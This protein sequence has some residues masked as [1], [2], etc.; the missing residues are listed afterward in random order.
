MELYQIRHFI[1]VA[2]AGGFTKGAQH[3]SVSQSAISASIAKIEAELGVKLLDRRLSPVGLTYAGERFFE[4]AKDIMRRYDA[5]TADLKSIARPKHLKIGV[6][7]S[8]LLFDGAI[9][10]LLSS[11]KRANPHL[12]T[13]VIDDECEHLTGLLAAHEIDTVLTMIRED[14]AEL[15]N[16]VLYKMPYSLAVREDHHF[17]NRKSLSLSDLCNEPFILPTRGLNLNDLTTT[18]AARGI[19]I[20]VVAKTDNVYRAL[21]LVA[22]GIGVAV[23]PEHFQVASV[24]QIPIEELNI[25]RTIGLVWPH[26]RENTPLKEFVRFAEKYCLSV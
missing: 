21:A 25:A 20:N 6:L 7:R 10:K 9:S 19:S 3:A 16:R 13:E 24:K 8:L 26:G 1:A 2:E 15:A 17:A 14:E 22:A 4:A 18:L 5:I 11:F 23:V 12:P